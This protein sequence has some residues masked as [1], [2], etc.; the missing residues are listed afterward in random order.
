MNFSLWIRLSGD[1][2]EK[3]RG[4]RGEGREVEGGR[5]GEGGEGGIVLISISLL[6]LSPSWERVSECEK[7]FSC[8]SLQ[9]EYVIGCFHFVEGEYRL[10]HDHLTRTQELLARDRG[11]CQVDGGKLR[12]FLQACGGMLGTEGEEEGAEE[13]K[14]KLKSS[15]VNSLEESLRAKDYHVSLMHVFAFSLHLSRAI[16]QGCSCR[17]VLPLSGFLLMWR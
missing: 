12:G 7:C 9:L 13:R 16:F 17:V 11:H 4:G 14:G 3:G 10:S 1:G 5:K 6:P 8:V 2:R 15:S